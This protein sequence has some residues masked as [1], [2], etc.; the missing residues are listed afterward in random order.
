[1]AILTGAPLG[2]TC[3]SRDVSPFM[4]V[5]KK[6]QGFKHLKVVVHSGTLKKCFIAKNMWIYLASA[7]VL[8]KFPT[9]MLLSQYLV[10]GETSPFLDYFAVFLC[11]LPCPSYFFPRVS[12]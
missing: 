10:R 9:K 6:Q 7:N 12:L 11:D 5:V 1:M 4:P 2:L 8:I 3:C